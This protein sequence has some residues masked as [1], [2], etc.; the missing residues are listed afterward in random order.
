MSNQITNYYMPKENVSALSPE[1][2]RIWSKTPP[3]MKEI[4]LRSRT[5]SYNDGANNHSRN[6]YKTVKPPS[7]PPRKFNAAHLHELLTKIILESSLSE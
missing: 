2:R 5:G 7:Y 6:V 1:V 4:I 3:D